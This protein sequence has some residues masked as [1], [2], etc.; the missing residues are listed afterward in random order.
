[1][2]LEVLLTDECVDIIAYNNKYSLLDFLEGLIDNGDF[3]YEE[4]DELSFENVVYMYLADIVNSANGIKYTNFDELF[5]EIDEYVKYNSENGITE[6]SLLYELL[7]N[8][9]YYGFDVDMIADDYSNFKFNFN[10]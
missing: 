4:L 3:T 8:L 5:S 2:I 9:E 6:Y 10:N 1:M 7:A